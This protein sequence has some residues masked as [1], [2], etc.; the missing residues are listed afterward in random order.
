MKLL[1]VLIL[2]YATYKDIKI[3]QVKKWVNVFIIILALIGKFH[4]LEAFIITLPFLIIAVKANAVG[5]GD[6]KFIFAN[7]CLLGI[8]KMYTAL[9]IGFGILSFQY[10][11]MKLKNSK[12]N[13][14]VPLIPYLVTGLL[15]VIF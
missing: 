8:E 12:M 10:L 5:G 2:I 15:Y 13:K 14:K 9:L 6:I 7:A 4:L 1:Y 3:L 11:I